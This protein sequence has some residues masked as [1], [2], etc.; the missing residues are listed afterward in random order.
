MDEARRLLERIGRIE[1][2]AGG[3]ATRQTLL[4]ELRALV[5]EAEAWARREGGAQAGAGG[6]LEALRR[7]VDG[8]AAAGEPAQNARGP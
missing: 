2:L 4:P 6:A 1:A 8:R 7:A 3:P 5:S